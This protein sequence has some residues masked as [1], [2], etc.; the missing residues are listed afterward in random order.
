MRRSLIRLVGAGLLVNFSLFITKAIIDV[1]NVVAVQ[2]FN[3]FAKYGGVSA[4]DGWGDL[5]YYGVSGAF[6]NLLGVLSLTSSWDILK[7]MSFTIGIV[8]S[9]VSA[10]FLL[11][12]AA[13]FG[14]GAFMILARFIA[15]VY[16][17]VLSPI[18]FLG[19]VL[20]HFSQYSKQWW[21]GFLRYSFFA[22]AY[23]FT[24]YLGFIMFERFRSVAPIDGTLGTI[25]STD[26]IPVAGGGGGP[27]YIIM[28]FCFGIGVMYAAAILAQKMSIAGSDS[29]LTFMNKIKGGLQGMAYR[30]T[31]G[32]GASKVGKA[33][34][35]FARYMDEDAK[36]NT[37]KWAKTRRAGIH[38]ATA[39]VA[40]PNIGTDVRRGI[41]GVENAGI[42]GA[43]RAATKKAEDEFKRKIARETKVENIINTLKN[44]TEEKKREVLSDATGPQL[45]DIAKSKD[46][47]LLI[48]NAQYLSA[49]KISNLAKDENIGD[50]YVTKINESKGSLLGSQFTTQHG[51]AGSKEVD[52]AN[53]DELGAIGVTKL[54]DEGYAVQ[55]EEDKI[56]KLKI[57]DAYKDQLKTKRKDA[58]IKLANGGQITTPSGQTLDHTY[59]NKKD[60]TK[61]PDD[62]F[63]DNN[64]TKQLSASKIKQVKKDSAATN[65][66]PVL[67][68]EINNMNAAGAADPRLT[69][70]DR[71]FRFSSDGRSFGL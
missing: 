17:M 60:I 55:L 20:P 68:T 36:K 11:I 64:F 42:G 56:D 32:W 70:I 5:G 21:S 40:T 9:F 45:S 57:D 15:L 27:A 14:I 47:D 25:L 30:N 37:G 8:Y 6:M 2:I 59:L 33:H 46:K 22:P 48:T 3:L 49:D 65:I 71:W 62:A 31:V 67:E 1:S 41:S 10:L 61:L 24:L 66:R 19:W 13:T 26:Y 58:L 51:S 4:T 53:L 16:Y 52:K 69:A 43:G 23:L 29:A 54:L 12:A 18:M 34:D 63:G 7:E 44:G 38:L 35:R 28:I 39:G 50:D